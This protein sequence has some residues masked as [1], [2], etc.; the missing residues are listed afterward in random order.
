MG[1]KS[2]PQR[3]QLTYVLLTYCC[4]ETTPKLSSW[5]YDSHSFFSWMWNLVLPGRGW[6]LCSKWC[7]ELQLEWLEYLSA[8]TAIPMEAFLTEWAFQETEVKTVRLPVTYTWK[9]HS[10]YHFLLWGKSLRAA[11]MQGDGK[12]GS[13]SDCR[14]QGIWGHLYSTA[15]E[16]LELAWKE[17]KLGGPGWLSCLS[18]CFL[19][20]SSSWGAWDPGIA[21]CWAPCSVGNLHSLSPWPSPL[22]VPSRALSQTNK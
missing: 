18:G 16:V 22:L 9:P 7:L 19:L 10:F 11:Q 21:L 2:V 4:A 1:W 8:G 20:G 5:K 13:I 3:G 17:L 12:L 15:P 6:H 14:E